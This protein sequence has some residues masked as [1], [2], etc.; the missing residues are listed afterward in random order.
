MSYV[1][2]NRLFRA[3]PV[4]HASVSTW[5]FGRLFRVI[6]FIAL[7]ARQALQGPEVQSLQVLAVRTNPW[8]G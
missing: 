3:G 6:G 2:G 7:C 8:G 5:K 4:P 1:L